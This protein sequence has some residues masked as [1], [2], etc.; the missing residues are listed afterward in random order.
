MVRVGAKS[1]QPPLLAGGLARGLVD[2][3]SRLIALAPI[4]TR[5]RRLLSPGNTFRAA[6]RIS[7]PDMTS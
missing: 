1:A 7:H 4:A 3:L 6:G 2:M 5:I